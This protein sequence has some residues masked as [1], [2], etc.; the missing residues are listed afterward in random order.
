M[1]GLTQKTYSD[2]ITTVHKR[3]YWERETQR[4]WKRK[5]RQTK[6]KSDLLPSLSRF[7]NSVGNQK[8]HSRLLR[9]LRTISLFALKSSVRKRE[10]RSSQSARP[11]KCN[12]MFTVRF[13]WSTDDELLK[14]LSHK[15]EFHWDH[16]NGGHS[17]HLSTKKSKTN[18]ET[19]LMTEQ[20][21]ISSSH[22]QLLA[23]RNESLNVPQQH[24]GCVLQIWQNR[25]GP[26]DELIRFWCSKV[27]VTVTSRQYH[28]CEAQ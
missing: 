15:A 3:T 20:D 7:L 18:K 22:L 5:R 23:P 16:V 14:C 10:V 9:K 28:P 25:L 6:C 26:E 8:L 17:W 27:K 11:Q 2:M 13:S 1:E 4:Y 12:C 21:V 24:E 19:S